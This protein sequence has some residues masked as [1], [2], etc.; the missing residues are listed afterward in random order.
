MLNLF[1][2]RPRPSSRRDGFT[3][4]ELLVVIAIIGVLVALLLPAVQA[5]REAARRMQC[6]NH[7]KQIGLALHNHHDSKL[8]F[9]CGGYNDG[10]NADQT[11]TNWAIEILPYIEQAALYS[12]YRQDEANSS[13]NNVLVGQTSL[14][15]MICPSASL[16][17]KKSKPASGP[18]NDKEWA[19]GSYKA[20]GGKAKD[21]SGNTT[22]WDDPKIKI[23][24][25]ADSVPMEWRGVLHTIPK[26]S[27]T[28]ETFASI[29]DGTS[30]TL[31]VGE[32]TTRTEQNRSVYWA[33]TP[34]AYNVGAIVPDG[35]SLIMEPDYTKCVAGPGANVCRRSF[36]SF[37]AG[38]LNFVMADG[39]V[40]SIN[41][42]VDLALLGN[43]ATAAGGETA[44][45]NP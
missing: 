27:L 9:P 40:R 6:T 15:T 35:G 33:F 26:A 37:H 31:L 23:G 25:A 10:E 29:I 44:I 38:S 41:R 24:T 5:A 45:V 4:V 1:G 39:S 3:L 21:S 16:S 43:M 36:A 17:V 11:R 22:W 13:A 34:W 2:S 20:V 8:K 7:L 12:S 18:G 28:E 14:P 30:N 42:T 19:L 32:Y